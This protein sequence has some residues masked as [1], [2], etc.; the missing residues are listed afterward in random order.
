ALAEPA[1]GAV[2]IHLLTPSQFNS[3]AEQQSPLIRSWLNATGYTGESGTTALL[4]SESGAL[5]AV[6]HSVPN[7]E[8]VWALAPLADRLPEGLYELSEGGSTPTDA[9]VLERLALGWYLSSYRFDRYKTAKRPVAK[10]VWPAG[11]NRDR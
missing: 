5:S 4:P 6:V 10:L 8:S 7:E 1:S 11:V 3:W 2:P 9:A